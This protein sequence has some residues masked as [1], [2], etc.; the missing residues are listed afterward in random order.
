VHDH[1]LSLERGVKV[2]HHADTPPGRVR[3]FARW[4]R[5]DLRWRSILVPLAERAF[6]KLTGLRRLDPGYVSAWPPRP[7]GRDRYDAA[8]ERVD[9][10]INFQRLSWFAREMA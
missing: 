2:R 7:P 1:L 5:E 6:V 8:R 4:E 10:Q 9:P 3:R